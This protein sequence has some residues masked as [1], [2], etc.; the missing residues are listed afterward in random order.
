MRTIFTNSISALAFAVG[1]AGLSGVADAAAQRNTKPEP[2]MTAVYQ[3][4][5]GE[6]PMPDRVNNKQTA[7]GPGV[8]VRGDADIGPT[9][10]GEQPDQNPYDPG[11]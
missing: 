8:V 1:L 4:Q 7:V 6:A 5:V 2:A 9:V 10:A 3:E 11:H